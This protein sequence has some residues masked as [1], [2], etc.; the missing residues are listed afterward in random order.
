MRK[1]AKHRESKPSGSGL[2]FCL[3]RLVN[4]LVVPHCLLVLL[5]VYVAEED[6]TEGLLLG[7]PLSFF[8]EISAAINGH[9]RKSPHH[10]ALRK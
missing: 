6:V 3:L 8:P 5:C 2:T 1:T 4:L 9:A 10:C 7:I